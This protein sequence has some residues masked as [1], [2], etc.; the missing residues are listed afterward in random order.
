MQRGRLLILLGIVLGLVTLAAVLI[1]ITGGVSGLGG[2]E[3]ATPTPIGPLVQEETQT[4][5]IIVALQPIPKGGEF[6][7]GSI[8]RRDWPA[9]NLPP[10]IIAHED[11]TIGMVAKTDI[12]QG[13]PI[14]RS[15][16]APKFGGEGEASFLIPAGR[17]AV[18]FP[19]S[20]QSSVAYAIQ[21]GD[22][23]DILVSVSFVDV[24]EEFQTKKPNLFSF[25]S[26]EEDPDTGVTTFTLTDAIDEGR[27]QIENENFPGF[28]FPREDQRPRL[29]AQ[30][31]VQQAKV[32]KI[33]PWIDTT[34]PAQ[35]AEE[36]APPPTPPLPTIVTLAVTP[37]DALVL[38]WARQTGA[39]M[40][41]AL[42]AAGEE[43]AEHTT[44][45]VTLQYMLTRF[46]IAIPPK[47]EFAI[48][49]STIP[50]L[51]TPTPEPTPQQ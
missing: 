49:K 39:Y 35:P 44:E 43:N 19:I 18:A 45:A 32:L 2:G 33:G 50:N 13:Q 22:N 10:E 14:V 21:Q 20:E 51:P 25:L 31:T 9:D 7:E 6:L 38:L 23:V 29:V 16:L 4:T 1:A 40:E 41:M 24:D 8:G 36:G 3:A 17:V 15:L 48:D 26:F 5:Q 34:A 37:Q 46:N 30:L 12:V 28:A 11:E 47:I 42:R 27:L